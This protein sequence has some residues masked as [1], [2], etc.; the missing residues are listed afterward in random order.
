MNILVINFLLQPK[1]LCPAAWLPHLS[2]GPRLSR[3][4]AK[5]RLGSR[6]NPQ[7]YVTSSSNILEKLESVRSFCIQGNSCKY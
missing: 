3:A 6:A 5:M 1:P 2:Q 7:G 4:G